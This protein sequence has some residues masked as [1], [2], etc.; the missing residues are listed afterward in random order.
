MNLNTLRLECF[1]THKLTEL[2]FPSSGVV[3]VTGENGSGKSSILEAVSVALWGKTLRGTLP[4]GSVELSCNGGAL[5]VKR[6]RDKNRVALSYESSNKDR[7]DHDTTSKGQADLEKLVGSWEVWR[8]T[9]VFSS[10]D[11]AHFS[12]A[13]DSER[14]R[15]LE[16]LLGLQRFDVALEGVKSDLK[17][18]EQRAYSSAQK[19]A[20]LQERV[21]HTEATLRFAEEQVIVARAALF[22]AKAC[23]FN[24][25]LFDELTTEYNRIA[26]ELFSLSRKVGELKA[27]VSVAQRQYEGLRGKPECPTCL[28][29]VSSELR[30]SLAKRAEEAREASER[31]LDAIATR[32]DLLGALQ[33]DVATDLAALGVQRQAQIAKATTEK[34]YASALANAQ[35]AQRIAQE[36]T[37]KTQKELE[38]VQ[39]TLSQAQKECI[40]LEAVASVLGMKGVRAQLF[41]RTLSALQDIAN[42]WLTKLCGNRF[43]VA[44]SSQTEKKS[45]GVSDSISLQ[46]LGVGGGEYDGASGGERRRVD[47][48]LLF[49]LAE[50]SAGAMGVTPGTLFFDEVLDRLDRSGTAAVC[51][52]LLELARTRCVVVISHSE[53]VQKQFS[54]CL[55]WKVTDG[56]VEV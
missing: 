41:G 51:E 36:T 10:S 34:L 56:K 55:H 40:T 17:T 49:A 19:L 5:R 29:A 28:R 24:S 23:E 21:K 4:T 3:L 35:Q 27:V 7:V 45:G 54:G 9:A 46:I 32:A 22:S 31:G 25:S 39:V 15:M 20:V 30:A 33:R 26:T 13:S 8:R 12:L 47:I 44:L 50:V 18:A 53:E 16:Y 43:S 11:E 2:T 14:K 6:K 37:S 48:A 1:T 38:A 52:A 42:A